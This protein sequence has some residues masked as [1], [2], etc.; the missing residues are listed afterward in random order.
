M[1]ATTA[2]S[3]LECNS[4]NVSLRVSTSRGGMEHQELR[5]STFNGRV[6]HESTASTLACEGNTSVIRGIASSV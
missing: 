5:V 1:V 2:Q 3:N 4:K 6:K